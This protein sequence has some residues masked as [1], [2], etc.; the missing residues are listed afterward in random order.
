MRRKLFKVGII[1]GIVLVIV[2]F[3]SCDKNIEEET[4]VDEVEE[5]G[6]E[7]EDVDIFDEP[8]AK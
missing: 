7:P 2:G 3:I 1:A 4:S 8:T 6:L 5:E